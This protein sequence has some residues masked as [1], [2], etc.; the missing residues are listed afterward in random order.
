M[1]IL[2]LLYPRW[3]AVCSRALRESGRLALCAACDAD[4]E[5]IGPTACPRC[6]AGGSGEACG[7][8]AGKTFSFDGATALGRYE[9]GLREAVLNLKFRSGR[10]LA[11]E[12]GRRLAAKLAR[13]FDGVAAVPMS[14]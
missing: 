14:G 8:C 13:R 7:E 11:D 5:W 12:F 4:L 3:C 2:D 6:G 10:P 1:A 9:G